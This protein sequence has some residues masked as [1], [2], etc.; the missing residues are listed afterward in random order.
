[1]YVKPAFRREARAEGRGDGWGTEGQGVRLLVLNRVGGGGWRKGSG[2][3]WGWV[4]CGAAGWR[5]REGR[6]AA[7]IYVRVKYDKNTM[8]INCMSNET[9][10]ELKQKVQ[11]I[12][13]VTIENQRLS[14]E[15]GEVTLDHAKTLTEMKIGNDAIVGLQIKNEG[16]ADFPPLAIHEFGAVVEEE[17]EDPKGKK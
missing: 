7:P 17:V 10:L 2:G 8:F 15:A 6:M 14:V 9:G 16:D 4:R 3:G 13:G 11:A 5:G 12:T 1:M